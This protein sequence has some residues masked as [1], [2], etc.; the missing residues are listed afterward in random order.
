MELFLQLSL[1][2]VT[3]GMAK[4]ANDDALPVY[5][6]LPAKIK[7]PKRLDRTQHGAEG[8]WFRG[9]V[10]LRRPSATEHY[11]QVDKLVSDKDSPELRLRF[12]LNGALNGTTLPSCV[13]TFKWKSSRAADGIVVKGE[14]SAVDSRLSE[15]EIQNER[16]V[17]TSSVIVVGRSRVIEKEVN[18]SPAS[19]WSTVRI[20]FDMG[21]SGLKSLDGI[22][23]LSLIFKAPQ[24]KLLIGEMQLE[25]TEAK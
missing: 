3:A 22:Y 2:L 9:H 4:G 25:P 8:W 7:L 23:T 15:R 18:A 10:E 12:I 1:L 21:N 14:V 11:W 17:A 16:R 19:D 20:P 13:L 6:Q 24:C 5:N